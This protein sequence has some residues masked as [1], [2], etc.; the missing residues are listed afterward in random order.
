MQEQ[1]VSQINRKHEDS[2][3][4]VGKI[5][6]DAIPRSFGKA[7]ER[8]WNGSFQEPLRL[9]I[10]SI[11]SPDL[12]VTGHL[13]DINQDHRTLLKYMRGSRSSSKVVCFLSRSYHLRG[14]LQTQSFPYNCESVIQLL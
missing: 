1:C 3:L 4:K 8:G 7:H 12:W 6:A 11:L 9:E 13:I 10:F 5:C 14:W 2:Y